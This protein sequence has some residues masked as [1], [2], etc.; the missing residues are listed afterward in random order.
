MN[1]LTTEILKRT[2]IKQEVEGRKMLFTYGVFVLEPK[3]RFLMTGIPTLNSPKNDLFQ[4]VDT[5]ELKAHFNSYEQRAAVVPYDGGVCLCLPNIYPASSLGIALKLDISPKCF[6]RMTEECG[7][8]DMLVISKSMP[9]QP[10]RLT[11]KMKE[12]IPALENLFKE[13]KS[14]FFELER[15]EHVFGKKEYL[16]EI[17]EQ[18]ER[19]SY[20]TGCPVEI[21]KRDVINGEVS[22]KLDFALFTAFVFMMLTAARRRSPTRSA[23]IL[24]EPMLESVTVGITFCL[25]E[26]FSID[27]EIASWKHISYDKN[28]LFD[29]TV[30]EDAVNIRFN[31]ARSEWSLLGLKQGIEYFSFLKE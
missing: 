31:P 3:P 24:L 21:F 9:A 27:G 5:D 29:V 7:C 14:C 15:L 10:A 23:K 17:E 25:T 8:M 13:I 12:C 2:Y 18:C 20:F 22:D 4:E 6:L 16:D 30:C 19:I 26:P 28:M 1:A 11:N